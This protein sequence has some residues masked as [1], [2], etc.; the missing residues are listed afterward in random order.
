MITKTEEEIIDEFYKRGINKEDNLGFMC[1]LD[2]KNAHEEMLKWLKDNSK[3]R[4]D[5]ILNRMIEIC[6]WD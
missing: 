6:E 3:A 2:K 4:Y 5:K 1:I